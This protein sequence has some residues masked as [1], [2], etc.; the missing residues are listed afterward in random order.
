MPS[1]LFKSSMSTQNKLSGYDLYNKVLKS[2]KYIVAP[3]VD[4]SELV[5]LSNFFRALTHK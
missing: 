2:P 4:Q 3:M 1:I 5:R